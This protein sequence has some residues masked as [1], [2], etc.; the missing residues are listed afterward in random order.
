MPSRQ[1]TQQLQ[2]SSSRLTRHSVV[3][4]M[5][6]SDIILVQ[7]KYVGRKARFGWT[8]CTPG[9]KCTTSWPKAQPNFWVPFTNMAPP[10]KH[11]KSLSDY[12]DIGCSVLPGVDN[13]YK[14]AIFFEASDI[15]HIVASSGR[16]TVPKNVARSFATKSCILLVGCR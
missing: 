9:A 3:S 7:R 14:D 15:F 4:L 13:K 6:Q 2:L 11:L 1:L 16:A 8:V 12:K 5:I 10:E